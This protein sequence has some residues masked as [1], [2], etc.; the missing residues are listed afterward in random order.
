[1]SFVYM[2]LL[3]FLL[4]QEL[5]K[6]GI[7]R[8]PMR[9]NLLPQLA[10]N[11]LFSCCSSARIFLALTELLYFTS[12]S[13]MYFSSAHFIVQDAMNCLKQKAMSDVCY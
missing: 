6:H 7:S 4:L 13:N 8:V 11:N 12:C 5:F 10:F 3:R 1:M 2:G 9:Q